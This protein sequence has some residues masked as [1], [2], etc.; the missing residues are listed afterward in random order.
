MIQADATDFGVLGRRVIAGAAMSVG[1][2]RR[3][4]SRPA[5]AD[6]VRWP[7]SPPATGHITTS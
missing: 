2:G 3:R 6:Y 5:V 1:R 7:A 4:D